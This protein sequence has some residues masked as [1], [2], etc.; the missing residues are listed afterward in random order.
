MA[1]PWDL[2]RRPRMSDPKTND[3]YAAGNEDTT[4]LEA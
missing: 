3:T 4:A 1:Q 2:N